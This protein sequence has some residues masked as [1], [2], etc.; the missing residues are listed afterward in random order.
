MGSPRRDWSSFVSGEKI[1]SDIRLGWNGEDTSRSPHLLAGPISQPG[2]NLAVSADS[3]EPGIENPVALYRH[4][5]EA[6]LKAIIVLGAEVTGFGIDRRVLDQHRLGPLWSEAKRYILGVWP[7]GN[8]QD[9]QPLAMLVTE[10]ELHE[11]QTQGNSKDHV[12]R[13]V[14][15][16]EE[17]RAAVDGAFRM[18][19]GIVKGLR[20][21]L[22]E[23]HG[24][25]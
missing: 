20:G 8:E 6:S 1:Q 7:E 14:V 13:R 9:F 11:S 10:F 24:R 5:I 25:S 2:G 19:D 21:F 23:K 3:A 12:T 15:T 17:I 4:S 22:N 16:D 18:L